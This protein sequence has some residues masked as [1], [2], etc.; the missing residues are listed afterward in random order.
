MK[1]GVIA[2]VSVFKTSWPGP[3]SVHPEKNL[4]TFHRIQKRPTQRSG[5]VSG[6]GSATGLW[7]LK[8]RENSSVP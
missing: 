5:R 8:T 2:K 4:I 3:V 7:I 6:T 1:L